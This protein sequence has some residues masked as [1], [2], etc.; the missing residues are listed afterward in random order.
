MCM[1]CNSYRRTN[2]HALLPHIHKRATTRILC[3]LY[4]QIETFYDRTPQP[5]VYLRA[6][7]CHRASHIASSACIRPEWNGKWLCG[8]HS[9]RFILLWQKKKMK[10][11]FSRLFWPAITAN[12]SKCTES[13]PLPSNDAKDCALSR[14]FSEHT[15]KPPTPVAALSPKCASVL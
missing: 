10:Q 4:I 15:G 7:C 6:C 2:P 8:A 3:T 1:Q 13:L 9:N 5:Y 12:T 14:K 11:K